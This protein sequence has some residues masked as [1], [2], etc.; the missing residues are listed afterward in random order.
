[1]VGWSLST[2][3]II[4]TVSSYTEG[5]RLSA[6][7]NELP[8]LA[9]DLFRNRARTGLSLR[10]FD[11]AKSDAL[12]AVSLMPSADERAK[13]LNTKALFRAASAAYSLSQFEESRTLLTRLFNLTPT[14]EAGLALSKKIKFRL[15]EMT[16]GDYNFSKIRERLQ[17]SGSVDA[18]S[19]LARTELRK[20]SDGGTGL[21]ALQDIQ[22]GDVVFCEKAF[23]A[24]TP[25]DASAKPADLCSQM[26]FE[27]DDYRR[28]A[29]FPKYDV[30][31]WTNMVD[32][33]TRNKS[34]MSWLD[35]GNH[36][37]PTLGELDDVFLLDQI[38]NE[39]AMMMTH[40]ATNTLLKRKGFWIHASHINHSCMPNTARGFIGDLVVFR[41]T[42]DIKSNEELL[43]SFSAML[44]DFDEFQA[45][46]QTLFKKLCDCAICV[47]ERQTPPMQRAARQEILK[48]IKEFRETTEACG[49]HTPE[50]EYKKA[51]D[52]GVILAKRLS[53]TYD[54]QVFTDVMPRRGLG[55]LYES[56]QDLSSRY[57]PV[58]SAKQIMKRTLDCLLEGVKASGCEIAINAAGDVSFVIATAPRTHVLKDSWQCAPSLQLA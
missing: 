16:T 37:R 47:A 35:S 42:R 46:H 1:M 9:A 57:P 17:S 25:Q 54:N 51:F 4:L 22:A 10:F 23:V 56:L 6:K 34:T 50:T 28:G 38:S 40:S 5:I 30:A 49:K 32:K 20:I 45:L 33:V 26:A 29:A 14:D 12:K 39:K 58:R 13:E 44:D 31:L 8:K 27:E 11:S 41:A 24:A 36:K 52:K 21:F 48:S 15:R 43:G 53:A 3:C 18:A 19:Y 2:S 7:G 55:T